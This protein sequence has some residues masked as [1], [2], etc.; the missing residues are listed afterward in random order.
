MIEATPIRKMVQS[1]LSLTKAAKAVAVST[2]T[3]RRAIEEKKLKAVKS[4]EG[5]WRIKVDELM[6]YK[7]NE[8]DTPVAGVSTQSVA[9]P[10]ARGATGAVDMPA[11]GVSADMVFREVHEAQ[12]AAVQTENRLHKD[13]IRDLKNDVESWKTQAKSWQNH[14]DNSLRLLTDERAKSEPLQPDIDLELPEQSGRQWRKYVA[15]FATVTVLG[16]G[17]FYRADLAQQWA[18]ITTENG[19]TAIS[20]EPKIPQG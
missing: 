17:Y 19:Q 13:T 12:M 20:I 9:A 3:L 11:T 10:A 2:S 6:Q 16:A 8:L 4:E 7:A 1:P 14:A 15:V 5:H 18:K